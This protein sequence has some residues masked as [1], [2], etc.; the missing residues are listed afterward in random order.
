[1]N[2]IVV[3][4]E[5]IIKV[6]PELMEAVIQSNSLE[7]KIQEAK[8]TVQETDERVIEAMK[9]AGLTQAIIAGTAYTIVPSHTKVIIDSKRFKAEKPELAEEYSKTSVVKESYRKTLA[10]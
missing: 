3:R 7:V 2:E 4:D 10:E 8:N 1:M 6:A 9:Q 5:G